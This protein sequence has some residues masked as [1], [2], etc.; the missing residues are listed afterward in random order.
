[1][2]LS[3]GSSGKQVQ[4]IE[5]NSTW[6]AGVLGKDP[7]GDAL[8]NSTPVCHLIDPAGRFLP[9]PEKVFFL[10]KRQQIISNYFKMCY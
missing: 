2:I 9:L 3:R 5:P 6:I 10:R 8:H 7:N 4:S 1:M